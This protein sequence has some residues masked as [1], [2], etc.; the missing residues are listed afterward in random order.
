MATSNQDI[1]KDLRK[2]PLTVYVGSPDRVLYDGQAHSISTVDEKGPL[3]VLP[4]HE[5]FISIIQDH[6]SL[7]DT[8]D[9]KQE[10]KLEAGV[11]HVNENQVEIFIGVR[12]V[13]IEKLKS[14]KNPT[15]AFNSLSQR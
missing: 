4:A 10:F 6:V 1:Y 13:D 12:E 11:L 3:D 9:K 8:N 14:G 2:V 15:S 5:N 7:I